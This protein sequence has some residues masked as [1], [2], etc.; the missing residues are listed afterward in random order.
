VEASEAAW[1]RSVDFVVARTKPA[2]PAASRVTDELRK[3]RD[4]LNGLLK[5]LPEDAS[6]VAADVEGGGDEAGVGTGAAVATNAPFNIG[7]IDRREDALKAV[8]AAADYFGRQEPLSPLGATLR[9][10]DRRARLSLDELLNELIPDSGVR[11]AYYWR[12]GIKPPS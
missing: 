2:M 8:M 6:D 11:E 4:W 9:E 12:S 10:V 1:R 3:M 5:K 7:R